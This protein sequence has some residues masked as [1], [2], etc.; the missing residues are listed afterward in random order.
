M[1]SVP[2]SCQQCLSEFSQALD[3]LRIYV[4]KA[5]SIGLSSSQTKE[6]IIS[7]EVAHELALKVMRKYMELQGKGPYSGSRDLTVEAFH[8]EI[9]HDGKA[10]LDIIIDRIQYNPVYEID[11]HNS[12]VENIRRKY[13][14]LFNK[15][16]EN[17]GKIL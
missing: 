13:I 8:A 6:M 14:R 1:K 11:T 16:E 5:S 12:Y 4:Q 7:F 3:D 9:I 17:M 10:W 15:F 2:Q